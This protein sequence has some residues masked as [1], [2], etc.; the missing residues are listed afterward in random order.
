VAD[1]PVKDVA[2]IAAALQ[3][4]VT[5]DFVPAW[6]VPAKVD[7]FSA[8]EDVPVG[9]WPVIV[10]EDVQGAAGVH[11]YNDGQPFALVEAGDSWSLTAS[12]S[13]AG[14]EVVRECAG[15]A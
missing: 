1:V 10:V 6:Q 3:K 12:P 13:A 11:L 8:L 14:V 5:R 9:Y 2:R 4:Q 7:G 15:R